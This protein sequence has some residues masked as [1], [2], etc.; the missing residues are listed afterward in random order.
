[1]PNTHL[2]RHPAVYTLNLVNS[3]GVLL[4]SY[5]VSY[6]VQ[7][8]PGIAPEVRNELYDLLSSDNRLAIVA[9][10]ASEVRK[11]ERNRNAAAP[12]EEL[13]HPC[14]FCGVTPHTAECLKAGRR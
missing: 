2:P 1:M 4:E 6:A 11:A 9:D 5:L 8:L 14:P 12:V 13:N 3:E 10:I 7:D